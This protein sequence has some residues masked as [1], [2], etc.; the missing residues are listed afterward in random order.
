MAPTGNARPVLHRIAR[1]GAG[2]VI[3]VVGLWVASWYVPG[4]ATSPAVVHSVEDAFNS[5]Y[6]RC[7]TESGGVRRCEVASAED[8]G[9]YQYDVAVAGRCWTASRVSAPPAHT[10]GPATSMTRCVRLADN[11]RLLDRL[12]G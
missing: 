8:S 4:L 12:G 1:G 10:G 2:A 3:G 11:L 6:T 5:I 7:A 9:T